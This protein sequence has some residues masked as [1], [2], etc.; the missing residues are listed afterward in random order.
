M[1]A[2]SLYDSGLDGH[3]RRSWTTLISFGLQALAASVLLTLP[4]LSTRSLPPLSFAAH[5]M[6]PISPSAVPVIPAQPATGAHVVAGHSVLVAPDHISKGFGR[7]DAAVAPDPF[8]G[9]SSIPGP[10]FPPGIPYSTG[11]AVPVLSAAVTHPPRVSVMMEGNLIRRVQPRYPPLAIQTRTQGAVVLRAV[12]SREGNIE[13]LQLLSGAPLL[14][15]AAIDAVRQWRYQPY[16][17]N[18]EA[19]EV[20][21]QIT[22]NFT[23]GGG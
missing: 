14:V 17:L 18:H 3:S 10:D 12:I 4:L 13:N 23:L 19:V 5:L 15:K 21:T 7:D 8:I 9:Q 1:F 6:V 22:V 16:Y 20:D 2:D 11:N